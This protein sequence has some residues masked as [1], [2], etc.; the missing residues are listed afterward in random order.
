MAAITLSPSQLD[1]LRQSLLNRESGGKYTSVN[2]IGYVGGYQLG[3]AALIDLGY[4]AAGTTNRGLNNPGS[5]NKGL[6]LDKFLNDPALQDQVFQQYTQMNYNRL[7]KLGV[8]N[9]SSPADAVAG[10]LATSHLLGPG[11]ARKLAQGVVGSDANGTTASTY[12]NLG[13]AAANGIVYV[14]KGTKIPSS[15][16][17]SATGV[18]A[19]SNR[20]NTNQPPVQQTGYKPNTVSSSYTNVKMEIQPNPL[21]HLSTYN[22]V[23]TFCVLTPDEYNN[24]D[25][26]YKRGTYQNVI[27]RSGGGFPDNRVPTAF[28]VHPLSNPNGVFE[29]Y[30]DNLLIDSLMTYNPKSASS[31]ATNIEFEVTEPYSMGIFLQTL[32]IAA[33]SAG[34]SNYLDA[35]YLLVVEFI[36]YD[37]TNNAVPL[38]NTTRHF[39]MTMKNAAMT[40]SGDGCKYK[41]EG[42]PSNQVA[43][44]DLHTE[45]PGDFTING[46]TVQEM[47]QSGDNSLQYI[48]NSR[49]IELANPTKTG[50]VPDEIV[51]TFPVLNISSETNPTRS[52]FSG[53]EGGATLSPTSANQM[54]ENSMGLTMGV[55]GNMVQSEGDMNELGRSR[56]GFDMATGGTPAKVST[57]DAQ[58]DGNKP[59]IQKN[60]T[61]DQ[62]SRSMTFP[63]GTTIIDIITQVMLNSG[64]CSDF[65]NMLRE[66]PD[67]LVDWFKIETQTFILKSSDAN[68]ASQN[69]LAMLRV[70]KVIPYTVHASRFLAAGSKVPGYQTLTANV[71]KEYNYLY[72]GVN[73]DII[74]FD[75]NFNAAF[76]NAISADG[77]Q[78]NMGAANQNKFGAGGSTAVPIT[79][80]STS[81]PDPNSLQPQVNN[82]KLFDKYMKNPGVYD[83]YASV[84]AKQFHQALMETGTDMLTATMQIQ[85]DPYYLSDSGMGNYSNSGSNSANLTATGAM[86]YQNGQV[87]IIVNYRTPIDIGDDGIISFGGTEIDTGF[88]GLYQVTQ[89]ASRW[90][91]GSFTQDLTLMR[92]PRQSGENSPAQKQ[93]ASTPGNSTN[94]SATTD[95]GTNAATVDPTLKSIPVTLDGGTVFEDIPLFGECTPDDTIS[96]W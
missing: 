65:T 47:L 6:T 2:Q 72:S 73:V 13:A 52:I 58:P 90:S 75:L 24:P 3:A 34:Y 29:Y 12:Y 39:P 94:N 70:Y 42:L 56:M 77:S 1:N 60:V 21:E 32:Q 25:D 18:V 87:D 61:Y 30:V 83:T 11:G 62:N 96:D 9:A 88:S 84:I 67:G 27:F 37:D 57:E 49:N 76:Y 85:G 91:K 81:V 23:F 64:Y 45:I 66:S 82:Y 4:V 33:I 68:L 53:G 40:V 10:Y 74:K 51:I 69:R 63:Q 16:P 20:T 93:Q 54:F 86:D 78:L 89:V 19:P 71:V 26:S 7:V 14:G 31:N 38:A 55:A 95:S 8:V 46:S 43:L 5:W 79:N 35:K 36:G 50:K 59:V 22:S 28:D 92:R 17:T 15:K 80:T 41:V 44:S 48:M